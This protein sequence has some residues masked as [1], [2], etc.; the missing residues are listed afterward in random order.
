MCTQVL[1]RRIY[2]PEP[3]DTCKYTFAQ[4]PKGL[5]ADG[6]GKAPVMDQRQVLNYLTQFFTEECRVTVFAASCVMLL[7]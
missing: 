4:C 5:E 1:N 6:E 3:W 7:G 2:N